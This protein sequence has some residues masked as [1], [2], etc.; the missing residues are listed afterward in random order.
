MEWNNFADIDEC[1]SN[2]CQHEGKCTDYVNGYKCQCAAGYTGINC[3]A[4]Q[5]T[6]SLYN[7]SKAEYVIRFGLNMPYIFESLRY[8]K[9]Q[10]I[11]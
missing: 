1:G 7:V 5:Y 2:P 9:L 6:Q 10:R 3:E 4:G 8:E 11:V